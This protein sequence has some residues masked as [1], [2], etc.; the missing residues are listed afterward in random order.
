MFL[1]GASVA[2]AETP[3]VDDPSEE[4]GKAYSGTSAADVRKAESS[5]LQ[6][7]KPVFFAY[8]NPLTKVQFSFKSQVY[9][10]FPLYMAYSQII[11]WELGKDSKPFL[12]GTY[13][14]EIFYRQNIGDGLL[15]SIDLGVWEHNS[16]GKA[17]VDSRSYDQSNMRFNFGFEGKKRTFEFSALVKYIYNNDE[18]NRDIYDYIGP[19][20][21]QLRLM[22][23]L[24]SVLDRTEFTFD[25][26]PGGKYGHDWDKS[27]YQFGLNFHIG[28]IKVIPAFYI[29]YYTGYAETLINY[30]QRV[31]EARVGISF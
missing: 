31:D 20:E 8:G 29:Q 16:N 9:A 26:F 1:L 18:T 6:P 7:Y 22:R 4:S 15:K 23:I 14:P 17:G 11:F 3:S 30:N 2:L 21:F 25:F 12:D 28:G 24:E 27:G 10:D 19:F 13:N 5:I